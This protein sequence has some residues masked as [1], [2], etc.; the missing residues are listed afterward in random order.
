MLVNVRLSSVTVVWSLI[1]LMAGLVIQATGAPVQVTLGHEW[2]DSSN[3]GQAIRAAV[4]AYQSQ[5]PEVSIEIQPGYNDDKFAVAVAGGVAPDIIVRGGTR[6]AAYAH[7]GFIT[8]L[9]RYYEQ[10]GLTQADYWGPTWRRNL[11]NGKLWGI[12]FGADPNFGMFWNRNLLEQAGFGQGPR[13]VSEIDNMDKKLTRYDDAGRL[14]QLSMVPWGLYGNTNSLFTWALAFGGGF[15]DE[16][17]GKV[18]VTQ[19]GTVDALQWMADFA[20]RNTAKDVQALLATVPPGQMA[21][22]SG[23]VAIAPLGPWEI[24]TLERFPEVDLGIDPMPFVPDKGQTPTWIGGHTFM[25]TTQCKNPDA[26]WEVLRYLA[27]DPVGTA[28]L[29][30]PTL[31]FP[32]FKRSEVYAE[33]MRKPFLRGFF[34]VLQTAQFH[35]PVTP[36]VLDL[37]V[38]VDKAVGVAI[39]GQDSVRNVLENANKT[40]QAK[41]DEMLG[42]R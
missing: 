11:Y 24:P 31:W 15:F 4:S 23:R 10:A 9:N 34:N 39:N 5:H 35:T 33:Y 12:S 41:L 29:A 20:S 40:V 26:A 38:A 13:T 36:V 25:I 42:R 2:A 6:L 3:V 30:R 14:V 32:A 28:A 17:S 1:L 18:A 21:I 8:P 22:V 27:G 19:Q 37:W 16:A 7:S